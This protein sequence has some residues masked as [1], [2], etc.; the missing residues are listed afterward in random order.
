MSKKNRRNAPHLAPV[1]A[2]PETAERPKVAP[3]ERRV[4]LPTGG[5]KDIDGLLR[6]LA[7]SAFPTALAGF[8]FE[9]DRVTG[10]RCV[11]T[12]L[13]HENFPAERVDHGYQAI[14]RC[15]AVLGIV[16]V[17]PAAAPKSEPA[18][19]EDGASSQTTPSS[20]S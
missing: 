6:E 3:Y 17:R 5:R 8:S 1:P 16:K 13:V 19:A 7:R 11:A 10:S 4:T 12:V 18:P 14:V 15:L 20:E 2:A 9:L